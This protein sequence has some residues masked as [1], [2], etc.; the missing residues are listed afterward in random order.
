MARQ[1]QVGSGIL[2][3]LAVVVISQLSVAPAAGQQPIMRSSKGEIVAVFDGPS[4]SEKVKTIFQGRNQDDF[5]TKN[6]V[7]TRLMTNVT[8]FVHRQCP[9]MRQLASRGVVK[10]KTVYT[11]LASSS[12]SWAI[13]ERGAGGTGAAAGAAAEQ[14]SDTGAKQ[15]FRD[16]KDF[17]SY[18]AMLAKMQNKT[19]LCTNYVSQSKTCSTAISLLN[20]SPGAAN[21]ITHSPEDSEGAISTVETASE[22]KN[23]FICFAPEKAVVKLKADHW[24]KEDADTYSTDLTNR[25][26]DLAKELC[27]GFMT[28]GDDILL[29]S[30]NEKGQRVGDTATVTIMDTEPALKRQE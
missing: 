8:Q 26:K 28:M 5:R 13:K 11:G 12:T 16:S 27:L 3:A 24:S 15:K 25:V 9:Q 22:T 23:G 30:Y 4:C 17:L 6:G 1:L 21:T 7:A 2:A 10:G 20:A 14:E 18:P 19:I 29:E